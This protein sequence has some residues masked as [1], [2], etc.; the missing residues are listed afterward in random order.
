M[1]TTTLIIGLTLAAAGTAGGQCI[2]GDINGD[3]VVNG[4][5]LSYVIGNWG[6]QCPIEISA[7]WPPS[8]PPT[9]GTVISI[10][11]S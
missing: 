1:K 3:G 11:G 4:I 6:N 8:G 7:V 5:D 10:T 9:G 2:Q